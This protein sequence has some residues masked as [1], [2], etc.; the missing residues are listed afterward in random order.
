M[1]E[2]VIYGNSSKYLRKF[3]HVV[4]IVATSGL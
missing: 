3:H 4:V 1:I 2:F